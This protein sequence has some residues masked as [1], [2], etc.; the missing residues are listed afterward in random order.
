MT[1]R[2]K[3]VALLSEWIAEDRELSEKIE[4]LRSALIGL[5]AIINKAG[6]VNLSHGVQ[7]GS[8][9]WLMKA[10]DAVNYAEMVLSSDS[11]APKERGE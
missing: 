5:V 3:A 7:L 6:L 4:E 11:E 9:S 10:T 1:D 8:I 2:E